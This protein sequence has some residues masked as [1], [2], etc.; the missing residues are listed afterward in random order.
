VGVTLL[1]IDQQSRMNMTRLLLPNLDFLDSLS[2]VV[3]RRLR[4]L[5]MYGEVN[6]YLGLL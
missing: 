5:S 2:V 6:C 4:C 3:Q 1:Y